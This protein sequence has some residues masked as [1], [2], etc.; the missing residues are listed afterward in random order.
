M[1]PMAV[2]PEM[3]EVLKSC[4]HMLR[5]GDALDAMMHA[6]QEQARARLPPVTTAINPSH[7]SSHTPH[8][9]CRLS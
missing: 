6:R 8:L 3:V 4:S 9:S 1:L 7:P 2:A 5:D